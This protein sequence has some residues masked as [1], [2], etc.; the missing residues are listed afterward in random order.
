[1]I[2][3]DH[4][5]FIS[6]YI[7]SCC[8]RFVSDKWIGSGCVWRRLRIYVQMDPW[9]SKR[10]PL[11]G[12]SARRRICLRLMAVSPLRLVTGLRSPA[13]GAGTNRWSRINTIYAK[14]H[15]KLTEGTVLNM[16]RKSLTKNEGR[17]ISNKWRTI[18]SLEKRIRF[19]IV[20]P[21]RKDNACPNHFH[22][23]SFLLCVVVCL[24]SGEE[25]KARGR[26]Q[27]PRNT[28]RKTSSGGFYFLL[29]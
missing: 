25:G 5:S 21:A 27:R 11:T 19:W 2:K 9:I 20:D 6:F 15:R 8:E 29:F 17:F 13:I 26:A 22:L 3:K 4:I 23:I 10:F 14:S 1:M 24:E 28:N 18:V 12:M 16:G 7:E